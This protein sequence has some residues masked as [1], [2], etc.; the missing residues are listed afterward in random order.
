MNKYYFY[1]RINA[2][3]FEALKLHLFFIETNYFTNKPQNIQI[4]FFS[5]LHERFRVLPMKK[6][7]IICTQN[8]VH[9]PRQFRK[10]FR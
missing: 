9:T 3:Y 10:H 4:V 6:G 2:Y 5:I 7:F 8:Q 1:F